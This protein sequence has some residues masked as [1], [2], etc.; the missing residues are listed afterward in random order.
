[1]K[2]TCPYSQK[3][4]GWFSLTFSSRRVCRPQDFSLGVSDLNCPEGTTQGPQ[5]PKSA[6]LIPK[7]EG[8]LHKPTKGSN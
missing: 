4:R 6:R 3:A 7:T 1:M 8:I 2:I 5:P